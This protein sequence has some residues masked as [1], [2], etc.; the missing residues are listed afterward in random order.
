MLWISE[1]SIQIRRICKD[2]S[3]TR[4]T[5]DVAFAKALEVK[6]KEGGVSGLKKLG[7][8]GASYLYPVFLEISVINLPKKKGDYLGK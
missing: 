1:K 7:C 2:K 5:I 4:A 8:F 6:E 3:I